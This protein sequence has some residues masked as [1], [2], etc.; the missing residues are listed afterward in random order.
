MSNFGVQ[1]RRVLASGALFW[2]LTWVR[3]RA[4]VMSSTTWYQRRVD[5]IVLTTDYKK[6]Q[7]CYPPHGTMKKK[8]DVWLSLCYLPLASQAILPNVKIR[9]PNGSSGAVF[10]PVT[11]VRVRVTVR[12]VVMSSTT[13]Y[14]RRVDNIVL[15]IDYKKKSKML[16]TAWYY[17]EKNVIYSFRY[18]IYPSEVK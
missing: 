5:N 16:S 9:F 8:C 13:W 10:W 2:P 15:T 18:V 1:T 14:Q 17:E 4:V 11:R 12:A 7:R 3:V 6:S